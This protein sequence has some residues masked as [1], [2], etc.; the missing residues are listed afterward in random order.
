MLRTPL[1]ESMK[2]RQSI[3]VFILCSMLCMS[4]VFA[5]EKF[6]EISVKAG[7]IAS[8]IAFTSWPASASPQQE[9]QFLLCVMGEDP[10]SK[11]FERALKSGIRG[12]QLVVKHLSKEDSNTEFEQCHGLIL[13]QRAR[14]K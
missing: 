5:R 13:R 7:F 1:L 8:F 3:L 4:Q 2:N 11:I 10:Y 6:D 9:T 14:M 12:R